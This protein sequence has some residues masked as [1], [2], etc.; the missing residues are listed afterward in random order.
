MSNVLD[1][2]L[3]IVG[4]YDKLTPQDKQIVIMRIDGMSYRQI[5]EVLSV[6]DTPLT[7]PTLRTYFAEGGKLRPAYD[8]KQAEKGQRIK[9]F[10]KV[11]NDLLIDISFKALQNVKK[12][13]E[14]GKL[15][16]SLDVLD[17][18]GLQ[19]VLKVEVQENPLIALLRENI[20]QYERNNKIPF[21]VERATDNAVAE[22]E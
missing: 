13:V 7:E 10:S 21:Q 4:E 11:A 20:Q 3:T 12:A 9:E 5:S 6:N 18:V 17:R 22:A 15:G 19:K 16:V 14:D 2:P 8:E 1:M